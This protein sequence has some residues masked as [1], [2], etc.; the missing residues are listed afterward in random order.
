MLKAYVF[1]CLYVSSLEIASYSTSY[2]P[3]QHIQS[4]TTLGISDF[5]HSIPVNYGA[6]GTQ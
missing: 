5:R 6:V 1:F 4:H 3:V 2:N